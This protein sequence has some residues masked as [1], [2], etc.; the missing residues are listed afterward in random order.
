MHAAAGFPASPD[1]PR[2]R[3]R[4]DTMSVEGGFASCRL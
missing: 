4:G 2:L 1:I 3:G